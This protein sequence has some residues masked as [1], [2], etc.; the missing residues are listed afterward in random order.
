MNFGGTFFNPLQMAMREGPHPRAPLL[1]SQTCLAAKLK[2][3]QRELQLVRH[4]M[5][6]I[7]GE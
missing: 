3:L 2:E 5:Q 4:C 6:V 1:R 7:L